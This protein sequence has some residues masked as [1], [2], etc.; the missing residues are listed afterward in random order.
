MNWLSN[1]IKTIG[2]LPNTFWGIL[3]LGASMYIAV[4][5]N[6]DIGYYFAGVG[7]TLLGIQ[8]TSNAPNTTMTVDS[9]PPMK[10]ETNASDQTSK[11]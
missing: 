11:N 1:L 8:H 7:S 10:V 5:Y 6:S 2:N 3:I 4:K 9:N